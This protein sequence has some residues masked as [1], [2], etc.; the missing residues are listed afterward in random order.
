MTGEHATVR[1]G[2]ARRALPLDR[3]APG[4]STRRVAVALAVW[5]AWYAAYRFYYGFGGHL[6]M[7]GHPS[8]AQHF[9]RDNLLGG[10]IILVAA[11]LPSIAVSAWRHRPVRRLSRLSAG[12][13][14]SAAA[15]TPS[16]S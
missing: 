1:Q 10:A 8:P 7:I 3:L 16:P 13:P 15:C 12:S 5:A 2:R 6:G 4:P 11:L 14:R 9:C